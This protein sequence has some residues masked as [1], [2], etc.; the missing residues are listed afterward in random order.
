MTWFN[1]PSTFINTI[2]HLNYFWCI[3]VL[4]EYICTLH[5]FPQ[6]Y[7]NFSWNEIYFFSNTLPRLYF[8]II[9]KNIVKISWNFEVVYTQTCTSL[10]NNTIWHPRRGHGS[11]L[12]PTNIPITILKNEKPFKQRKFQDLPR[13]QKDINKYVN[14][15]ND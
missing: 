4:F 2:N 5:L 3:F 1:V 12:S 14:F 13:K 10:E 9:S 15:S 7:Y 8:N 11:M 6:I